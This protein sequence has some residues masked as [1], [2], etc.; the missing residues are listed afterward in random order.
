MV[1]ENSIS[2]DAV[3]IDDLSQYVLGVQMRMPCTCSGLQEP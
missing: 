1:K 3:Y 2:F